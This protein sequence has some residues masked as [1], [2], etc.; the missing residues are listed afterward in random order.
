MIPHGDILRRHTRLDAQRSRTRG[1]VSSPPPPPPPPHPPHHSYPV[2]AV[3]MD[4][5]VFKSCLWTQEVSRQSLTWTNSALQFKTV[6][7]GTSIIFLYTFKKAASA[8]LLLL[9]NASIYEEK[10]KQNYYQIH[11]YRSQTAKGRS[12]HFTVGVVY[13]SL[14]RC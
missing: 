2:G 3:C 10:K 14:P 12:R 8:S 9:L 4:I 11:N 5:G 7:P 13:I 6:L 1:T